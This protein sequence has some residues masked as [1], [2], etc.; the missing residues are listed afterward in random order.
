MQVYDTANRLAQEMKESEEY[1]NYKM[2]KQAIDLNPEIKKEIEEFELARYEEQMTAMQT[3]KTDEE[4]MKKI[5]EMYAE[6]IEQEL[7]RKFFDAELKFNILLG[8]VNKIISE[9]VRDLME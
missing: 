6:L 5:Q 2:A 9:A 8:D 4:K 1:V 3:G 7:A